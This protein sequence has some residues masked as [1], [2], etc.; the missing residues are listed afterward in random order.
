MRSC[1]ECFPPVRRGYSLTL[2]GGAEGE[3]SPST[4]QA[5]VCCLAL[6]DP[7]RV[8]VGP[9]RCAEP[10]C[11]TPDA[12]LRMHGLGPDSCQALSHACC[13]T[14]VNPG[15]G[16]SDVSASQRPDASTHSGQATPRGMA[17][18]SLESPKGGAWERRAS[19]W[20]PGLAAICCGVQC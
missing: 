6:G 5:E 1:W 15:E 3:I 10:H 4:K 11:M 20:G 18:S 7:F 8:G 14:E 13:P 19:G 16:Q 17:T 9:H 12:R 2:D